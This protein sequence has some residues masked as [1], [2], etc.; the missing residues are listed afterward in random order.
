MLSAIH[1]DGRPKAQFLARLGYSRG[2]WGRLAADLRGQHLILE[3][4]PG[5]PSP[6]GHKYEILGS[7]TGPNG[8][9]AWI[10]TVWI[11]RIGERD[12]RLVTLIPEEK[13]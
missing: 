13:R 7:L 1:R 4:L 2:D 5:K 12:P 3:A 8:A 11:V 6:Y 10:R 9:T